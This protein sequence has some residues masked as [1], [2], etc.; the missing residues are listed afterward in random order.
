MVDEWI[1]WTIARLK[2][3]WRK[4]DNYCEETIDPY[5]DAMLDWIRGLFTGED[6]TTKK[7]RKM[8]ED[9]QQLS[10]LLVALMGDTAESADR[11]KEVKDEGLVGGILKVLGMRK[12][13]FLKEKA[14][15]EIHRI[16]KVNREMADDLAE[17]LTNAIQNEAKVNHAMLKTQVGELGIHNELQRLRNENARL[18][19]ENK[20]LE[21]IGSD[22]DRLLAP[23]PKPAEQPRQLVQAPRPLIEPHI[24]QK[25]IEAAILKAYNFKT[26]V[27]RDP[28]E[29][30]MYCDGLE[31][32]FP[33]NI[34]EE[35]LQE[36]KKMTNKRSR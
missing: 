16:L 29:W 12:D 30:E 20:R 22:P 4:I 8:A 25:D 27:G 18:M 5:I 31:A 2:K 10:S 33:E 11:L 35:I 24:S 26:T 32:N 36:V 21:L 28:K 13:A 19:N 1:D 23:P 14:A 17:T 9:Q 3:V 15:R 34:Y 6:T 7:E